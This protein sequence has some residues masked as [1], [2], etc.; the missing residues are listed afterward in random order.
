MRSS[1]S[2]VTERKK[3]KLLDTRFTVTVHICTV[4]VT[5]MQICIFLKALM[6]SIF[7]AKCVKL[8]SFSITQ[9]SVDALTGLKVR[10]GN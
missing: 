10:V 7:E 2:E 1:E 3:S 6:W 9:D 5:N 4:T 8:V